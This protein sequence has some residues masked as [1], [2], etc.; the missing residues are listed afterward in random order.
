MPVGLKAIKK[1]A[2]ITVQGA[3]GWIDAL[4]P[5]YA[6][7]ADMWMDTLVDDFGTDHWYT[8]VC[9]YVCASMC[10]CA[11]ASFRIASPQ[12]HGKA[13][14]S[15]LFF[16]YLACAG[17]CDLCDDNLL[18]SVYYYTYTGNTQV[19]VGW[20]L[21]RRDCTVDARR[22]AKKSNRLLRKRSPR[23]CTDARGRAVVA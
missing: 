11:R 22:R 14:C 20:V 21:E 6:E 16:S 7:V 5:L 8:R 9:V 2:N 10:L 1:D 4:D 23:T 12:N 18:H 17:G 15:R 13:V 19:P 3:T